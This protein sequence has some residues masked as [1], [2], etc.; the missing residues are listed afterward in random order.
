MV[1]V[2]KSLFLIF[3]FLLL[4]PAFCLALGEKI[5]PY[6]S[7]IDQIGYLPEDGKICTLIL[8][9]KDIND[10]RF[11]IREEGS[12]KEA[13]SGEIKGKP[14]FD[15]DSGG[16]VLPLDFSSL[17]APGK[18]YVDI[19]GAKTSYAFEIDHGVYNKLFYNAMRGFYFQRCGM[20]LKEPFAGV[21]K[22]EACHQADAIVL[23][24]SKYIKSTGGWHD[25][26][27]F[28]KKVVPGA[29]SAALLLKI[30]ELFPEKLIKVH[31]NIPN[32]S[33]LPDILSET[34]YELDWMLTMQRK[35]G[36]VY[37]L[38]A[39]KD[40]P[41][42]GTMPEKDR[43]TRYAVYVSSAAT[44]DFAAVMAM[45]ARVYSPFDS[46][47]SATA[48]NASEKAWKFLEKNKRILPDGGY[49]DPHGFNGTGAYEDNDDRDERFWA[50]V[51]LY[52]TTGKTKY[53]DYIR[54]NYKNWSPAVNYPLSWNDMHVL[55]MFDYLTIH[56][57]TINSKIKISFQK[58]LMSYASQILER[59]NNDNYR[60]ALKSSDYY[61]GSNGVA[62]SY[63]IVLLMANEVK[64]DQKYVGGAL[65]QL[66]YVLGRNS[67]N[68]CFVTG[69]GSSSPM[70]PLHNPS[71]ADGVSEP[72]PGFLVGGPNAAVEDPIAA[73]Y[74]KK[75]NLP[76]A[77]C[78]IDDHFS[79]STN[80]VSI[81]WNALIVFVT[82]YF[83]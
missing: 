66:H 65:D 13:F 21:W 12:N 10:T 39:T 48:L 35:D 38:I 56:N 24:S 17:R 2:E 76:P 72:V 69:M 36:G 75:Y 42:L 83:L 82:G 55:G 49:K 41:P 73:D 74:K 59:I 22:R 67:L 79:Y 23:E 27:D 50:A 64:P 25:A 57:R 4:G 63:G 14:V 9:N 28:G 40:F 8:P 47:F 52:K 6:R 31:L 53:H 37:H 33:T 19:G 18:Y 46:K 70:N 32:N 68:L 62:L 15:S 81:Y 34:R 20:D 11:L 45:A 1:S 7:V 5:S 44:A 80:E 51:E 78:Y 30:Y 60:G 43:E 54:G 29:V 61:W 58:D 77:K 71:I 16:F 26:G 3:L